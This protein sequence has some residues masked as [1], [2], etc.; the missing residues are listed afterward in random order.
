V[1]SPD[2]IIPAVTNYLGMG[3]MVGEGQRM[4]KPKEVPQTEI[5]FL[6]PK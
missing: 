5:R 6:E 1:L 3:A 4:L 2:N